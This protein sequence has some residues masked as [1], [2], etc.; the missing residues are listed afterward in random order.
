MSASWAT[1]ATARKVMQGNRGRDTKPELAVRRL[2]HAR[3]MRYRVNA[4]V[5]PDIRRSADMLF[6]RK[7]IAVFIDGCYWHGCPA[8]F[9][10]PKAHPDYWEAKIAGN[11]KRDA[12]TNSLLELRGWTI[13][14]FWSHESPICVADKVE[15]AVR[16]RNVERTETVIRLIKHKTLR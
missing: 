8:H 15:A 11:R 4:R 3:G 1:S 14:R 13:L 10:L 2:V 5:E 9:V 12:E 16:D 6:T 7:R